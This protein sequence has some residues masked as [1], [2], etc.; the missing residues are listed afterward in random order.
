MPW[1]ITA[2]TAWLAV[3]MVGK[4]AINVTTDSGR[5]SSLTRI[6][7]MVPRVPSEPTM[8]PRRSRPTRS[9]ASPPSQAKLPSART[10]SIPSTWLVV[11][12]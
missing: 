10:T 11:T 12:P 8:T 6:R 4:A 5:G 7:V 1:P 9:G 2:E 3:S